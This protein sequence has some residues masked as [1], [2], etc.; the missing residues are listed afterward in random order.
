MKKTLLSLLA[1]SF[2]MVS[3][4][5]GEQKK[6]EESSTQETEAV[7]AGDVATEEG[8]GAA[9][10][11]DLIASIVHKGGAKS[12]DQ[13]MIENM[14]ASM[15]ADNSARNQEIYGH[16]VGKFGKNMINVTLSSIDG[17]QIEGYSVCAGN[18][19]KITGTIADDGSNVLHAKMDEPGTNQYDGTFEFTIDL[20]KKAIS[21]H[22][23]P[24]KTTGNSEKDYILKKRAWEYDASAGKY[25]GSTKAL[26]D[27][28]LMNQ[29][30]WTLGYIRNEIYARHGYSF[31]NKDWRY[32]FEEKKWYMPMGVD[33]RDVL[34]D[35]E[36]KNIGLIYEYESYY[37]DYYD[38]YGR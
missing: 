7:E 29:D 10:E 5:E 21:G 9:V 17:D 13:V 37:E 32:E 2:M 30:E 6:E 33:I 19:R 4:G 26:S 35:L 36:V 25:E 20:D 14:M 24:F 16:W 27:D 31:K 18:F 23:T 1:V 12:E 11:E 8:A 34:T 38:E 28:F 15:E 3:C 22:W